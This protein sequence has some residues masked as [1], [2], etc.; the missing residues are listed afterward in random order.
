METLEAIYKRKSTRA[1][2]DREINESIINEILC[3]GIQAPSPKNVQPWRFAVVQEKNKKADIA[4]ILESQ[5]NKRK[6][7][8]EKKRVCRRDI[9]SAFETVK[10]LKNA[11][12]IIFVYLD[13][14][15]Y[16]I[17]NDNVK[18]VL[19]AKDVECNHIM[20]IGAAIQNMLLAA[21]ENGVDSLWIGDFYY[22]Y[23][24]LETYL[25][26][27]S[28]C[29]VSAVILGYSSESSNKSSRKGLYE[30]VTYII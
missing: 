5:L 26:I 3:A 21:T 4:D 27:N 6:A 19:N 2:Y 10:I 15:S 12:A 30:V 11:S 28:G 8:N 25:N 1:F 23:N 13:T 22:A 24:Q 29:L 18:W 16:E 9:D 17:H 7:E 20:S 14:S